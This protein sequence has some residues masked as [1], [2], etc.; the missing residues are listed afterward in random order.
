MLIYSSFPIF[1]CCLTAVTIMLL[2]LLYYRYIYKLNF[3]FTDQIEIVEKDSGMLK[4]RDLIIVKGQNRNTA[5][6]ELVT[7]NFC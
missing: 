4:D 1:K 5:N 7:L 6:T 3:C 2:I